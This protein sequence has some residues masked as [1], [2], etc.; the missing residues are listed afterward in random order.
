MFNPGNNTK[1]ADLNP[2]K[3]PSLAKNPPKFT[4]AYIVQQRNCRWHCEPTFYLGWAST[5]I[6]YIHT[7]PLK[8]LH[9]LSLPLQSLPLRTLRL[10]FFDQF[11]YLNIKNISHNGRQKSGTKSTGV[12][13]FVP[14][15]RFYTILFIPL[16]CRLRDIVKNDLTA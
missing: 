13:L 4:T 6:I 15:R 5:M 16:F 12:L 10:V 11:D 8:S 9:L 1:N 14:L 3:Y 7:L 2:A